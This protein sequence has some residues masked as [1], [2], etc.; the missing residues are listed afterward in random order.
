LSGGQDPLIVLNGVPLDNPGIIDNIPPE[1]IASYDV[2]KD[3]S[4][5]AIYGSRG[6]NGVIMITTKKGSFNQHTS[7]DYSNT[8]TVSSIA[9]KPNMLNAAEWKEAALDL[10]VSEGTIN[11]LDKGA[12]TNWM[13]AVTRTAFSQ[14]HHFGISGGT[15]DFSFYGS[16]NYKDQEGIVINT[17]KEQLAMNFYAEKKAFDDRLKVTMGLINSDKKQEFVDNGIFGPLMY[18]LP[19]TPVYNEDGTYNDFSDTGQFNSVQHQNEQVNQ[20]KESHRVM[21][22]GLDYKL[23]DFNSGLS[24]GVFGSIS[25]N[26]RKTLWFRPVFPSDG[27]MNE[28]RQEDNNRDSNKGDIHINYNNSWGDHNLEASLVHEY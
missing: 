10:G 26:N 5:T 4:A 21:Y 28:A 25:K 11:S 12:D 18:N 22:G 16:V 23:D 7:I 20:G 6:A 2:L 17:G 9:K 15:E 13:D 8:F 24:V 14:N 27:A 3:Q 19:V 1:D